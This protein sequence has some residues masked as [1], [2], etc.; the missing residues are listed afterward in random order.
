MNH[1]V[2]SPIPTHGPEIVV[3]LQEV[4]TAVHSTPQPPRPPVQPTPAPSNE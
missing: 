4:S 1:T 2:N 3:P